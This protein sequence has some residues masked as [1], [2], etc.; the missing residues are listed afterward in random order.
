MLAIIISFAGSISMSN[1]KP[2]YLFP[3]HFIDLNCTGNES[4]IWDCPS[5]ALTACMSSHDAAVACHSKI[6]STNTTSLIVIIGFDIDYANCTNGQLRL[7]GSDTTVKGR[8]EICY[9]SVWFG[10]CSDYY[11]SYNKPNVVC[12]SLGYSFQGCY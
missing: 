12:T 9:N 8:V 10:V 5:N 7:F 4:T 3:F 2:E 11:S 1:I 6:I